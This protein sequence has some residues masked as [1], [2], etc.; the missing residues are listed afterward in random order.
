MVGRRFAALTTHPKMGEHMTQKHNGIAR[1]SQP[2]KRPT[3][4]VQKLV[5]QGAPTAHPVVPL[6]GALGTPIERGLSAQIHSRTLQD[7]IRLRTLML[8]D[9]MRVIR[10]V[11]VAVLCF[12]ERGYKA[13]LTGAQRAMRS[14]VKVELL[15][16]YRTDR[17][18]TVYGLTQ[19]GAAWLEERGIQASASVRR[20][21]DMRNPEH[22][23]WA[24][25]FTLCCEARGLPAM[26]EQ[27][28]LQHVNKGAG[29]NDSVIQGLLSVRIAVGQSTRTLALRP[30]AVA[31]E[32]DGLTWF[33]VDR[34]ARGADRAA[35]LKALALSMGRQTRLDRPLKRVVVLTRSARI[36]NRVTATLNDLVV[37]S[38]GFALAEGRRQIRE[39]A[40]GLFEVW[41]T[42]EQ[43]LP[44]G[45]GQLVDVLAGHVIVQALP[46][47]LPRVRLD[48]RDGHSTEGWFQ[49]NF[50]PYI[51]PLALGS[52]P[53][54]LSP[55]IRQ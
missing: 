28:L 50:L 8:A 51:R 49:E 17:F 12:P 3:Q 23:L 7:R 47:W 44:D 25:F 16:R 19:R 42:F 9:R 6:E 26:T 22:R 14:M 43:K 37:Q 1:A 29:A 45:R 30:D 2:H 18:Q 40:P 53:L 39:V 48:G 13:S 20:V 15:R 10:T 35:S 55:L 31:T 36:H 34:S 52:W 27:E 32:P 5:L 46:T 21:S 11:D 54:P 4:G 38:K 24:Q 41:M 33:E